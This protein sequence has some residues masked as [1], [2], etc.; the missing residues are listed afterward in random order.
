MNSCPECGSKTISWDDN[1][2]TIHYCEG[3][4]RVVEPVST[5]RE[6][7]I[8]GGYWYKSA[9]VAEEISHLG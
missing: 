7:V 8:V 5:K 3:C 2:E 4:N 9:E 1:G 6:G